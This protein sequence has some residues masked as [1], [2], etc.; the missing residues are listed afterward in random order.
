MNKS[1]LNHRQVLHFL[2]GLMLLLGTARASAAIGNYTMS[3]FVL[4]SGGGSSSGGAYALSGSAGQADAGSL[5][6]DGYTILGGF[7]TGATLPGP[8]MVSYLPLVSR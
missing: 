3:R 6:G 4:S 1:A 5:S 2:L 7:W 8:A